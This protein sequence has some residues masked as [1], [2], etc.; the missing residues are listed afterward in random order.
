MVNEANGKAAREKFTLCVFCGASEG[1]SSQYAEQTEA[2]AAAMHTE[3][4]SLIYGGGTLGLMGILARS[5]ATLS[6][7][8]AVHGVIPEALV[9]TERGI[10]K[11]DTV[12]YG[13]TTLVHS[14]H[15][16]KALMASEANAFVALPGGYGTV[17]EL[18]EVV[19][20]NQLGIHD[21]PVILFN[22]GGFFDQLLAWIEN[23][24]SQ[25]FISKGTA[26]II[27]VA[28]TPKEVVGKI[29]EYKLAA[30]RHLLDWKSKETKTLAI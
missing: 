28:N 22:I 13:K 2:L 26:G 9:R 11:P 16:R 17:E 14:M 7:P 4:W 15:E 25:G 21:R 1:V 23:S 19:T 18:F 5:L 6:G 8:D 27:S 12:Q 10:V 29:R 24:V 30:G 3:S 20:W